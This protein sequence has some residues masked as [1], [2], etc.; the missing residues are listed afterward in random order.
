MLKQLKQDPN[1]KLPEDTLT[2]EEYISKAKQI[3]RKRGEPLRFKIWNEVETT[4]R[5]I[6]KQRLNSET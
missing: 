1:I 6:E 2:L 4:K 3:V 5:T